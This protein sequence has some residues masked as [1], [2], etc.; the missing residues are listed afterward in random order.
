MPLDPTPFAGQ[1]ALLT[2][3]AGT[4]A[5]ASALLLADRGARI[6][7]VDRPGAD[8]AALR[9]A[10]PQTDLL[11]L[12]ADVADPAQVE[13]YVARALDR[14]GQIDVFFNAAG[15]SG[16]VRPLV[17][18]PVEDFG[19]LLDINVKG[20]FHGL[21]YVLPPMIARGKGAII[22]AASLSGLR[23][24]R[25]LCG[26]SASKHAVIGLT[27]VAA[28]ENAGLGIRINAIAPGPIEGPMFAGHMAQKGDLEAG[29]AATAAAIP[30]GR[31]GTPDDV[32]RLVAFLASD[33]AAYI[34]GAIVSV[35]GALSVG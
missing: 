30:Q 13:A 7:A 20:V 8:F 23:G 4:L 24:S 6:V 28:N 15:I 16:P 18:Y 9:S 19:A 22:N 14:F 29:R 5:A 31:L 2:G 33:E 3:A 35:D 11:T 1:V 27:K 32:A 12:E 34:N 25:G 26:Y 17:D 21:K 10:L